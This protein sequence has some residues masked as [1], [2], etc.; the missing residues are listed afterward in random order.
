MVREPDTLRAGEHPKHWVSG[1]VP[2]PPIVTRLRTILGYR[3]DD[4]H[5]VQMRWML[6]LAMLA[7]CST[8][9]DEPK[10]VASATTGTCGVH[11]D[12][13]STQVCAFVADTDMETCDTDCDRSDVS[14]A[15]VDDMC[16]E[17]PL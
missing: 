11:P 1:A 5:E 13:C 7:A 14:C 6:T 8:T 17:A 2:A 10:G 15:V 16:V 4:G 3:G 9:T 12:C